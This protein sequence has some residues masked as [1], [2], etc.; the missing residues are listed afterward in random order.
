MATRPPY[1]PEV[2]YLIT[3][4]GEW[5]IHVALDPGQAISTANHRKEGS[6][7]RQIRITEVT[8]GICRPLEIQRQVVH[9]ALVPEGTATKT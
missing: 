8:V 7:D 5:P 2:L 1:I 6:P 3:A 4:D 9:E